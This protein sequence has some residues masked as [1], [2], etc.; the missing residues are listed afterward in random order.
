M[1]HKKRYVRFGTWTRMVALLATMVMLLAGCV[2]PDGT[3]YTL[4]QEA[5]PVEADTEQS[6]TPDTDAE[7]SPADAHIALG[8]EYGAAGDLE[9]ALAELNQAIAADP[10]AADAYYFRAMAYADM[11]DFA[12]AIPDL[13][14]A[15]ALSPDDVDSLILR[16][17]LFWEVGDV[18]AAAADYDR[19]LTLTNGGEGLDSA[20]REGAYYVRAVDH[21]IKGDLVAVVADIAEILRINPWNADLYP[22]Y[23]QL[24]QS[25]A[26]YEEKVA[27]YDEIVETATSPGSAAYAE[28]MKHLLRAQLLQIPDEYSAAVVALTA[29]IEADPEMAAAYHERGV[30]RIQTARYPRNNVASH[31]ED[32]GMVTYT[33][34]VTGEEV[35]KSQEV[36]DNILAAAVEKVQT[37]RR[38]GIAD[39]THALE[40]DPTLVEAVHDLGVAHFAYEEQLSIGF[41]YTTPDENG[42]ETALELLDQAVETAPDWHQA[43]VSR[44]LASLHWGIQDSITYEASANGNVIS[45]AFAPDGTTLLSLR[46]NFSS[47]TWDVASGELLTTRSAPQLDS[48]DEEIAQAFLSSNGARL[49]TS[50]THQTTRIWNAESGEQLMMLT[51]PEIGRTTKVLSPDGLHLASEVDGKMRVWDATTGERLMELEVTYPLV[52]SA[53]GLQ[54]VGLDSG[55]EN[56]LSV[57]D[58]L[59]G[60]KLMILAGSEDANPEASFYPSKIA[61]SADGKNVAAISTSA[62]LRVWNLAEA[63]TARVLREPS[64][65]YI[66]PLSLDFSPNGTSLIASRGDGGFSIWDVASGEEVA[67][68]GNGDDAAVYSPDGTVIA[69]TSPT[70]TVTLRDAQ[71]RDVLMTLRR[72]DSVQETALQAGATK[73][74]EIASEDAEF[75]IARDAGEGWPYY[76]RYSIAL[77]SAGFMGAEMDENTTA[78]AEADLG[79]FRRLSPNVN[80]DDLSTEAILAVRL[81]S[82]IQSPSPLM[83]SRI[84]GEIGDQVL[85]HQ[86]AGF[87]LDNP[88]QEARQYISEVSVPN[89]PIQITMASDFRT[90]GLLVFEADL[91]DLSIEQWYGEEMSRFAIYDIELLDAYATDFGEATLFAIPGLQL[92]VLPIDS[93]VFIFSHARSEMWSATLGDDAVSRPEVLTNFV[94]G[95]TLLEE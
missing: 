19:T 81:S 37:T 18:A 88:I 21:Y 69:S 24:S 39:L 64:D 62:E 51:A 50:S 87:K 10:N 20:T 1:N 32:A 86:E 66:R 12:A 2:M 91:G 45:L 30:A 25:A 6:S 77:Q 42:R 16:A 34:P 78:Q 54:L 41:V 27:E 89:G 80:F 36:Y 22:E 43:R 92:A 28:G 23:A 48:R 47:E 79:T 11:G 85:V 13:D 4:P 14:R 17:Q 60:E 73:L 8:R 75:L 95:L 9:A 40:L 52:F 57:W 70:G 35:T 82:P 83:N 59:T 94:A 55:A 63:T 71:S 31:A 3:V 76:V 72:E 46:A 65:T 56:N 7:P 15:L 53:D 26:H 67:S 5:F 93:R 61:V 84:E 33:D 74:L 29:A 49:L 38:Q 44:M 90:Y 68:F 58:V